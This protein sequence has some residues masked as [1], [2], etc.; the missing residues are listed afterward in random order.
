MAAD[1]TAVYGLRHRA[2]RHPSG[3]RSDLCRHP[4]AVGDQGVVDLVA[5]SGYYDLVSMTLNTA[6]VAAPKDGP[7]LPPPTAN[8][9]PR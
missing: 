3:E 5:L 7:Q 4:E 1:E 6:Q 9:V 8:R 2:S